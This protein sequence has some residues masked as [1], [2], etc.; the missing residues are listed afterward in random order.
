MV[1]ASG[2]ALRVGVSIWLALL[3][4][5]TVGPGRRRPRSRARRWRRP[6][7]GVVGRD[8]WYEV[9]PVTGQPKRALQEAM[10]RRSPATG[11]P[12]RIEFHTAYQSAGLRI[13]GDI[14]FAE[15]DLFVN[16]LA[17]RDGLKVLALLNTGILSDQ[18]P[19]SYAVKELFDPARRDRYIDAFVD[20][21]REIAARYAGRI[22]PTRSSTSRTSTTNSARS[23]ATRT[24]RFRRRSTP[25]GWPGPTP[26]SAASTAAGRSSSAGCSRASR[27]AA[28]PLHDQLLAGGLR[29]AGGRRLPERQRALPIRRRRPPSIPNAALPSRNG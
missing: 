8:P 26:P 4:A 18:P 21:A 29:R 2:W 3:T 17:P 16:K 22:A 9:D 25:R 10:A 24:R 27:S 12:G 28:Q 7:F 13:A 14:N 11:A 1:G 15:T 5:V 6:I 23:P 19:F 20:R